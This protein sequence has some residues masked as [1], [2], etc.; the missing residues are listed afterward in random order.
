MI[1]GRY[2]VQDEIGRGGMGAVWRGHDT[3]LGRTVALKRLGSLGAADQPDLERASR[4]AQLAARLN[5]PHVVAVFDLVTDDDGWQW[6]V[7]EHVEGQSLAQLIATVGRVDPAFVAE[8]GGQVAEALAAAHDAGIVHRDVKPSNV[9]LP[10]RGPAKLSDFGIARAFADTAL[11]RTGLVTGSPAYLSPEVARG[12]RA[13]AA[14]DAWALGATLFHALAGRAPYDAGDNVVGALYRIA[15]EPPPRLAGGGALVAAIT[16]MMSAE[17]DDRPTL[18]EVAETLRT[19]AGAATAPLVPVADAPTEALP[20]EGPGERTQPIAA[21]ER[22]V[23][24]TPPAPIPAAVPAA[25]AAPVR[26]DRGRRGLDPRLLLV[27]GA[28]VLLVLVVGLTA[29][30]GRGGDEPSGNAPRAGSTST[31]SEGQD[32]TGTDGTDGSDGTSQPTQQQLESF[33]RDYVSTAADDPEDGFA[34]L[35]PAYQGQ[36]G[37]LDGYKAFWDGVKDPVVTSVSADP[38]Q[39]TV[40]YVYTYLYDSDDGE[41]R[42]TERVTLRLE[43][44]AGGLRIAG[45]S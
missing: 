37:G 20:A 25:P 31:P 34:L 41:D 29:L 22:H 17:P 18:R 12:S 35:T 10:Q 32:T 1:A 30:L 24:T 28:V 39:M 38:E 44:T 27:A 42:R 23:E 15:H 7:M 26:D 16:W 19:G 14:S 3:V 40:T 11:T 21:P 2:E 13:T 8:V 5:H 43:Q 36:S 4:E 9:L 45:A 6:L 33:A